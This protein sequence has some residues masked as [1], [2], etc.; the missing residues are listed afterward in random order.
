MCKGG[1]AAGI[2][3]VGD[4]QVSSF[5]SFYVVIHIY[6]VDREAC[7]PNDGFWWAVKP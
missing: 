3:P 4:P 1:S 7:V 6:I 2:T 5:E